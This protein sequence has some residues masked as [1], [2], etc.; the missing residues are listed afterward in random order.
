MI[1]SGME[2][3]DIW[4]SANVM[5]KYYGA[6]ATF[7]AAMRADALLD[8]GDTDGFRAWKHIMDAIE[9]LGRTKPS[10]SEPMN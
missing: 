6:D 7:M 5:L 10:S 4:R 8:Q 2:S 1:P 9:E 3:I